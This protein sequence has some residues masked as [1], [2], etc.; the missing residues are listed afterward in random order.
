MILSLLFF[1]LTVEIFISFLR[2]TLSL[3]KKGYKQDLELDD[4]FRCSVHDEADKVYEQL[5]IQWNKE[6]KNKNPS[7]VRALM[8][9]FG[10]KH[11]LYSLLIIGYEDFFIRI[12][13][14]FFMGAIINY[15]YKRDEEGASDRLIFYSIGFCFCSIS[16]VV[17][18][19]PWFVNAARYGLK[20]RV[21]VQR[22]MFEKLVTLPKS[23]ILNNEIGQIVN[24]MSNDVQRFDEVS[25][26]NPFLFSSFV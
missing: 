15:F 8:K 2:W 14:P 6:L 22:L 26:L 21:A 24:L 16:F 11:L 20:A 3:F 7:L 25:R 18:H 19:H 1:V 12:I 4:M 9:A 23:A 13:Q 5:S 10:Y 17:T